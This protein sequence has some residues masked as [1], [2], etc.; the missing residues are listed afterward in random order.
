MALWHYVLTQKDCK[1]SGWWRK[2]LWVSANSVAHNV[3]MLMRVAEHSP[4][5]WS[6]AQ[7]IILQFICRKHIRGWNWTNNFQRFTEEKWVR[8]SRC[9]KH[10]I[11]FS[12]GKVTGRIPKMKPNTLGLPICASNWVLGMMA[13]LKASIWWTELSEQLNMPFPI[14]KKPRSIQNYELSKMPL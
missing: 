1:V 2:L 13:L 7:F 10:A 4:K 14:P 9:S 8:L 5:P 12:F 11:V 6:W 3:N